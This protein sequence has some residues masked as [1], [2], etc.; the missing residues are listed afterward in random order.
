MSRFFFA[1]ESPRP[2]ALLRVC[3]GMILFCEAAARWPYAIE[4]YSRD[5]RPMSMFPGTLFEPI[6]PG[7]AATVLLHTALVGCLASATIGW[8]T[9]LS[10]LASAVLATWLGLL[11]LPGTY[12]KYSVIALHLT[13]L[14]ALADSGGVWSVDAWVRR[15][16]GGAVRPCFVWPRRLMQIFLCSVY[17]GAAVTKL[18]LPE[19]AAGEVLEFSLLDDLWGGRPLGH[20]LLSHPALL[21]AA[22][23]GT[24]L[25]EL[26]FPV[27]VWVRRLRRP[28]LALAALFHLS[29]QLTMH[30]GLFSWV[31]LAGLLSF[32]TDDD[33]T[34]IGRLFWRLG[35]RWRTPD[36]ARKVSVPS[37][38][39]ETVTAVPPRRFVRRAASLFVW[40][41]AGA[42]FVLTGF[43]I[44]QGFDWYGVFGNRPQQPDVVV[45][46]AHLEEIASA[47]PPAY[48]DAVHRLEVGHRV[49]N[50]RVFGGERFRH[51]D[52][53][54]AV[55]RFTRHPSMTLTWQLIA[56]DGREAAQVTGHFDAATSHAS[57]GFEIT[58]DAPAGRYRVIL[59][60]NGYDAAETALEVVDVP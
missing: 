39:G 24:I 16:A 36:D 57:A 38:A 11:D 31:M 1:E 30:L 52:V 33:L 45:E 22:S 59:Q 14:L 44:Q 19:F 34:A 37:Q 49:S 8:N 51:G 54:R 47:A 35:G 10:L 3:L 41:G 27:L 28:M 23:V 26:W 42:A 40:C 53:V 2:A 9:R 48:S 58:D 43:A 20:R 13:V 25:F 29:L 17:L 15:K 7:A 46:G 12:K 60:C 56:P 55:A 6:A 32:V 50:G 4:L 5:G 18:R 21:Q